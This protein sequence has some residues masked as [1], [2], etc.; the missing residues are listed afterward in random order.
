MTQIMEAVR[1]AARGL[2][3][4]LEIL[5]RTD[6]IKGAYDQQT[7]L[8]MQLSCRL[9]EAETREKDLENQKANINK[10]LQSYRHGC[11]LQ[12]RNLCSK[13]AKAKF[14]NEETN[15]KERYFEIVETLE[16]VKIE[17]ENLVNEKSDALILQRH[18]RHE[19]KRRTSSQKKIDDTYNAWFTGPTPP[20]VEVHLAGQRVHNL[21]AIIPTLKYQIKCHKEAEGFLNQANVQ[22]DRA[23][24]AFEKAKDTIP[25]AFV[26]GYSNSTAINKR[27]HHLYSAD[28]RLG[29]ARAEVNHAHKV[30]PFTTDLPSY[31]KSVVIE[32]LS[33]SDMACMLGDL[34]FYQTGIH[35]LL[36]NSKRLTKERTDQL[37]LATSSL[38][39]AKVELNK[40][41]R[42]VIR[43]LAC[44][45]F[46][47]MDAPPP[48]SSLLDT[49]M[50]RLGNQE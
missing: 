44:D 24:V 19:I 20:S 14:Q 39:D 46:I 9:E 15:M 18:Q 3:P 30:C 8:I 49:G 36:K 34:K 6:G 29:C 32:N 10:I 21:Q 2:E 38:A 41:K 37:L 27:K 35:V 50:A 16:I 45:N 23:L 13:E 22:M 5:S 47:N 7:R 4:D 33:Q 17:K 12:L 40:A 48:Y 25:S 42:Q 43:Q 28:K 31:N 1:S 11:R 26:M